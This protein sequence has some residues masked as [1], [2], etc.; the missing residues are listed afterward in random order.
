MDK[1]W[2]AIKINASCKCCLDA[3]KDVLHRKGRYQHPAIYNC[4]NDIT[5]LKVTLL[6][7]INILN[8]DTGQQLH[9]I[10]YLTGCK[11]MMWAKVLL[12]PPKFTIADQNIQCS[13]K[14]MFCPWCSV[15]WMSKDITDRMCS[16]FT[17]SKNFS[18]Q[19]KSW[20]QSRVSDWKYKCL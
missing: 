20:G 4:N 8:M 13:Q 9:D 1:S 12:Q 6:W 14:S 18:W 2:L 16:L 3:Q 11:T 15:C 17:S 5:W 10:T 7:H 19:F